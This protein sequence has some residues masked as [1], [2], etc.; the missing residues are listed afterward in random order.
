MTAPAGARDPRET[1]DFLGVGWKF[2]LQVT[3]GGGIARAR[4]EH[5]VE[6]SI[7]LILA[8]ARGE[9]AMLPDFGCGIHDLAF[10]P[11]TPATVGIVVQQVRR[12]L[13]THERRIDVLDVAADASPDEPNLLLIRIDYRVRATNAL[14]NL[15][16]PFHLREG[17]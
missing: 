5:R 8:T 7:Y 11:S 14:G 13:V 4:Y 6:E 17:A 15:V 1:R 3:P 10:A 12:A 16:Y 2:P 9:R